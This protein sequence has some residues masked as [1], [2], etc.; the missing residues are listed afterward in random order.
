MK[1]IIGAALML[2]VAMPAAA[3]V[4]VLDFKGVATT[5]NYT[6]VGGFY[7]GGVSGDGNSGPDYGVAFTDNALAINAYNGTNEPDPG[8]LFFLSGDAVNITYSAG[9]TTG[10]SFYY[11]SN[12]TASIKVY[13]GEGGTGNVLATLNLSNN[14]QQG[15]GYCVWTPIGVNF[16]GT[17]KSIDF[18]GGANYVGFDQ[19]TFGS[20]NPGGT[21]PE[22][23]TWAMMILG[24]GMVGFA[25]RRRAI[26]YA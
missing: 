8:V 11:A 9:F 10:F 25:T 19:I 7:D 2:G 12:T 17:A 6:T 20:R 18:A 4:V 14:F 16:S 24:F 21:V 1:M 26:H 22:P 3:E 13:D 15:C 5:N 23:A